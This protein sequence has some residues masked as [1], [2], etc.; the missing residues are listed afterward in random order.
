MSQPIGICVIGAGAIAERH[1]QAFEQ[2]GGVLPRWVI[3]RPPETAH[4][5]ARRWKFAHSGTSVEPALADRSVQL[6]LIAS[7]SPLHSEQAVQAMQAGKDAIVEIPVA[8]SWPD[9]QKV[10]QVAATLGRRAWVCHTLRSTAALRLV[11]E[12]VRSGRL[13]LTHISGFY[14]I[15]RRRNQ[16][17]GGIGTRT[18]ID[19]LLWH[20]GCHQVD[21][22]LWVLGMPAVPRVQALLGPV[23]PTFGMALDAGLQMV[24]A[25][26]ELITQSLSYNVEQAVW[27]LQF[28]GHE[29]VLT[30]QDGRLTNEAGHELVPEM[31]V[32]DLTVQN[33]ELLHAFRSGEKC[34]YELPAVLATMEVLGR[35]QNCTEGAPDDRIAES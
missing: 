23:H 4:E 13:H 18:W 3:S 32:V 34:E 28:I 7:P 15:P 9:A 30:F 14:R 11:R 25:G 22:S 8:L 21:A 26:G 31:P 16:G 20:H 5:F 19:N 29:D 17:M 27:R 35:A 24:T 33:R 10:A 1:M 6:V 12:Q 2:L